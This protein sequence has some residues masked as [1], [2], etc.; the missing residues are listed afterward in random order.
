MNHMLIII[1]KNKFIN[2]NYNYLSHILFKLLNILIHT[3]YTSY[4]A[5]GAKD[6]KL[7]PFALV[8]VSPELATAQA[9]RF[10]HR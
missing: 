1:N 9:P 8:L 2:N 3:L 10:P 6:K 5:S 7:F 4:F